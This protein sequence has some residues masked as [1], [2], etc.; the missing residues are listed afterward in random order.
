MIRL[1]PISE[2]GAS[3]GSQAFRPGL[4]MIGMPQAGDAA[5]P[6]GD[7]FAAESVTAESGARRYGKL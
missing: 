6:V 7:S 5:T 1:P 2:A 4:S 3:C